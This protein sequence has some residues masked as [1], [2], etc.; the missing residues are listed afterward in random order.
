MF[1]F[2]CILLVKE[3]HFKEND[4]GEMFGMV[5]EGRYIIFPMTIFALYCG[6]LYNDCFGLSMNLFGSAYEIELYIFK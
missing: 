2:A 1:I 5:F 4:Y 6:L 3:K